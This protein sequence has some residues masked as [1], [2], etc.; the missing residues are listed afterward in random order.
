MRKRVIVVD[1]GWSMARLTRGESEHE[2][3][4]EIVSASEECESGHSPASSVRISY[5]KNIGTLRDALNEMFSVKPTD[6]C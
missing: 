4:I 5:E 2:S 6:E 1:L 3:S